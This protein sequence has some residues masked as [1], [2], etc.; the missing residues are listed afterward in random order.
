MGIF[1][2]GNIT[3]TDNGSIFHDWSDSSVT[4]PFFDIVDFLASPD[5]LP[6]I[7]YVENRLRDAYLLPWKTYAPMEQL[8]H[9][10]ELAKP[11]SLYHQVLVY[12]TVVLPN[13]E[14]TRALGSGE[15]DSLLVASVVESAGSHA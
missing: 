13:V 8:Q 6:N 9:A 2:L 7:P 10:Y 11:L 1:G 15:D 4:H 5:A 12:Q 3:L 14:S